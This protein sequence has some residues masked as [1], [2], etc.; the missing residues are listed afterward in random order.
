MDFEELKV[1]WDSQQ[2]Q[3]LYA[4]DQ[5]ALQKRVIQKSR[6]VKRCLD[7]F[8]WSGILACAGLGLA[9]IS[10]PLLE[11]HDTHQFITGTIL[12]MV[13]LYLGWKRS[14]RQKNEM[15]FGQSLRG[16]LDKAISQVEYQIRGLRAM[17]YWGG[18]PFV[19]VVAVS[20]YFQHAGRPAWLWIVAFVWP[21]FAYLQVQREIRKK[22][23]PQLRDFKSL[24]DKLTRSEHSI[25]TEARS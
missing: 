18:I 9:S 15:Q 12:L 24:R 13:A 25:G 2:A 1:I 23:L 7:I 8:E 22:Y 21:F 10:E 5:A 19:V 4:F 3:P 20:F 16:T 14:Q 11:G 17:I 6:T